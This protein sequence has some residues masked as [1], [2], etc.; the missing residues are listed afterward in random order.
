MCGAWS[1][2]SSP[3]H[4]AAPVPDMLAPNIS[5]TALA[6]NALAA[7]GCVDR[8]ASARPFIERCQN[9]AQDHPNEFD[10]GG[11]FFALDDPIR[12]KAGIAGCDAAGRP[13]FRSYGSATCDGLLALRACGFPS[14]HPRVQ[15]AADWLRL[16]CDGLT[17]G[18]DWP[19]SRT[20]A[21][22]SL[23]FYQSQALATALAEL[24]PHSGWSRKLRE[25]ITSAL[26]AAQDDE[27][28]WQGLAPDSCEDEPL[29][30]SAFAVRA[31]SL[32]T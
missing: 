25:S 8:G 21:R 2:A 11:F 29:L 15:A 26:I 18:G 6:L 16:H 13:R 20:E 30:A 14:G 19:G 7:V 23:A 10:D 9:F 5:A 32:P 1:D 31:L 27:G 28:K 17:H 24:P 12:N 22:D 4:Y 3:P